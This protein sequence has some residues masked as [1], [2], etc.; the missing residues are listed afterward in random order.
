[1]SRRHYRHQES[2]IDFFTNIVD[3]IRIYNDRYFKEKL[4]NI[5]DQYKHYRIPHQFNR[6]TDHNF[7]RMSDHH[8]NRMPVQNFNRMTNHHFDQSPHNR[9][10]SEIRIR[11]INES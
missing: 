11:K 8:F 9:R 6:G 3:Q 4:P 2:N 5:H 7:N 1:M 10:D